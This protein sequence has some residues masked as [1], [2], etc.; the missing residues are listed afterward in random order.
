MEVS[1]RTVTRIATLTLALLL[2]GGAAWGQNKD[3]GAK[4][5]ADEPGVH[6]MEIYN[7]PVRT[8][9]YVY[10]GL[11]PSEASAV[12]ELERAENE[13]TLAGEMLNLRLQYVAGERVAE[14]QRRFAQQQLYGF[15]EGQVQSTSYS[16]GWRHGPLGYISTG[17]PWWGGGGWGWGG[18]GGGGYGYASHGGSV[19]GGFTSTD[20]VGLAVGVGD[21]G[22]IKTAM[23]Q[24]IAN[25]ATP[26]YAARATEDL[27][28]ATA[29]A[30]ATLDDKNLAQIGVPKIKPVESGKFPLEYKDGG[31]ETIEGD[32]VFE[33][34]NWIIFKTTK[35]EVRMVP[36]SRLK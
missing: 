10:R 19:S 7:G 14:A 26:D 23:A 22:R 33:N 35:G 25:Q 20:S 6:R 9:H 3:Q 11:S 17:R 12:R 28:V 29:L 15:S 16:A 4:P 13:N 24:T 21:E 18:W 27:A 34:A 8:V 1:M 2:T 30:S 31:K 36:R 32:K 5:A